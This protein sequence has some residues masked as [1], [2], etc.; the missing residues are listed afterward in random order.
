MNCIK[1]NMEFLSACLNG[2]PGVSRLYI[3][4]YSDI[5][6]FVTDPASDVTLSGITCSGDTQGLKVFYQMELLQDV[7]AVVD[8]PTITVANGVAI[9]IP[10]VK[11]K[12]SVTNANSLNAFNQLKRSRTVVVYE[13]MEGILFCTGI[14][15]GLFM[16]AGTAGSDEA[17]FEGI[18]FELKGKEPIGIY[19]LGADLQA[20]FKS[21][22]VDV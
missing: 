10:S 20:R 9:S 22:Y 14:K 6:A 7:G 2:D 21:T 16:S 8:T 4:N 18:T 3:A 5:S 12:L 11:G 17:T 19:I 15:R 13:N 1:Y